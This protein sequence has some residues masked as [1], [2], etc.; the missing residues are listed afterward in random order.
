MAGESDGYGDFGGGGSVHYSMKVGEGTRPVPRPKNPADQN[1][2]DK[3]VYLVDGV[4]T[5][6]KA[7]QADQGYFEITIKQPLDGSDILAVANPGE[8]KLYLP[9]N[10]LPP[11]TQ[12]NA[13]LHRQIKVAWG[14]AVA[15]PAASSSLIAVLTGVNTGN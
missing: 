15:R 5:Y 4:D 6:Q 2:P 14:D 3:H 11:G 1:T 8:V 12:Y 9:V 13:D 10:R 7:P